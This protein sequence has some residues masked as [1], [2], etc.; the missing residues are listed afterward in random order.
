M[1]PLYTTGADRERSG[2]GFTV[3]QTFMDFV[4]VN[5]TLGE[6]TTVIMK[7]CIGG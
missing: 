5:S 2:M 7:K 6:G 4:S 1:Q 3:M